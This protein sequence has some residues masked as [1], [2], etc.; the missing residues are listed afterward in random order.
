LHK[1]L[2]APHLI[3]EPYKI[4]QIMTAFIASTLTP[5][6]ITTL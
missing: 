4:T 3:Q 5:N 6:T 2:G 1:T